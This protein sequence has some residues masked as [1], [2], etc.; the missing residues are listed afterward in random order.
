MEGFDECIW[1]RRIHH[2][3]RYQKSAVPFP[4]SVEI[5]LEF[6]AALERKE[7]LDISELTNGVMLELCDFAKTVTKSETYFLF[8]LLEFNFDIGV[9][10]D[11]DRQ[12][13]DYAR[14]VHGK[15]KL[16][17]DQIKL[18]PQRWK[19]AFPLPDLG[20][21]MASAGTQQPGRYYPKRNKLVD[22]S[23]LSDGSK[24]VPSAEDQRTESTGSEFVVKRRR[25]VQVK[26]TT[27]AYPFCKDLGVT[28]LFRPGDVRE[29]KVNP[30]LVTNGAM[31]ELLDFSRL[32]CGTHTGIVCDLV[33]QNFGHELE[34]T[35][36]R[37]QVNKLMERKYA[38]LTAEHKDAFRKEAF[39]VLTQKRKKRSD[40]DDQEPEELAMA[41]K[42]RGT[43]RLRDGDEDEDEDAKDLYEDGDLSY[44]CPV[45]FE[46]EMQSDSEE[47][48]VGSCLIE[49]KDV[50][51]EEEEVF[52]SPEPPQISDL[53]PRSSHVRPNNTTPNAVSDLFSEDENEDANVKTPKQKLWTRRATRSKQI[54]KSSRV[55]DLFARCRERGLD[56]NVASANRQNLD[57]QILSNC[58]LLEVYK[59][60]TA[61]VKSICSFF[62]EILDN[63]FNFVLQ[64]EVHQRNFIFYMI[65]KEKVLQSH[66][67]RW[68]TEFLKSP[69]HF[70]EVY[71]MV[72][73][74]S[75]FQTEQEVETAQQRTDS[76]PPASAT[77]QEP[78]PFCK[79]INLDL[80]S[81]EERPASQK[82]DLTVLTTGAVL[83][84][85]AFV[86]ELCGSV[87]ET[88]NDLLEHNFDVDLQ[89]GATEASQVIH[90]W[91]AT[92]KSLMQ[93]QRQHTSLTV[94]RWLNTVV[95]LNGHSPLDPQS[96]AANGSEDLLSETEVL[97]GDVET[98]KVNGYRICE[99]I[100]LDLDVGFKREAKPKLDLRVLT[101]GVLFEMHRY[102][103][104]NCN[105]YVPAL[106]E[107]LEYN[108][109][110]SSQKH[111]KVEFAWAVASQ[112]VTIAAKNRRKGDYLN[113]AIEL[114]IEDSESSQVVCKDEPEDDF[115]EPDLN[116]HDVVFVQEM[117][118]VDIEV[119][120]D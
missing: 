68:K 93:R 104:Q 18:K 19:E 103:E 101:R 117:K 2:G 112:V 35:M 47:I 1:R 44:M 30:N 3:V 53:S 20:A 17:R 99:G 4:K 94:N 88:V 62:F 49:I 120:I 107:I 9:D 54:L 34:K 21:I 63:N 111:R 75:D 36:F 22:S 16:L 64:D 106:Y 51:E 42:R 26:L 95:P 84:V 80:W 97:N 86:R 6:N 41:S 37:A 14:R 27:D 15:A 29:D 13:Y 119:R 10:V 59:F 7:K 67:D 102:V 50:K 39:R 52:V 73:V 77:S 92:Q 78:H 98:E 118:P 12:Y 23:V 115:R 56:F 8:E 85:F 87:R 114:P 66:P 33:T 60:A 83:E 46:T 71:N 81:M 76:D 45:E 110:L 55:N 24:S 79:K 31:L 38:C 40:P 58:V 43:L 65:T 72:D 69:F 11:D 61:M 113:R 25:G 100:G 32:L 109:D 70:P 90:R 74:T 108:F 57:L 48:K 82:L 105:R 116:D 96:S 28:L 5:G 91:Y 89:S